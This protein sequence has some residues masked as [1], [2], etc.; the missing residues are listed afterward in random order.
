MAKMCLVSLEATFP[1]LSK[2]TTKYLL[3]NFT[4]GEIPS[5]KGLKPSP[6]PSSSGGSGLVSS[7]L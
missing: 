1:S 6:P 7:V 4:S 2:L 3:S 5:S